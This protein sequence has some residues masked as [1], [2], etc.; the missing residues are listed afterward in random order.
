M[1]FGVSLGI[2]WW[3]ADA[4]RRR[5]LITLVVTLVV[6]GGITFFL[7]RYAQTRV[8]EHQAIS[9]AE[10]VAR[11]AT[12]AR[13]V[14]SREVAGKLTRDGFGPHNEYKNHTGFVPLPSQF[15]KLVGEAAS[16]DSEELYRYR[17]L[18]KWNLGADQGLQSEFHRWAWAQ[19]EAQDKPDPSGPI[20]WRPVWRFENENG[21][22]VLH[23]MRA[24][25]ASASNCVVCHNAL[26][27]QDEI[28]ARRAAAGLTMEKQ[29][30]LH[31]LMGAIEVT[32]PL[33]KVQSVSAEQ[34]RLVT[35][36]IFAALF[37][38]LAI[39]VWFMVRDIGR[40]R[41]LVHLSWQ[42]TH[43][44]LTG[45]SNRRGF[46]DALD[47]LLLTAKIENKQHGL[48]LLD[49]DNFKQINDKYGH[50][51]GDQMLAR[52]AEALQKHVRENDTVARL[53]GD[54]F[55][56]LLAGCGH[57]QAKTIAENLRTTVAKI[58]LRYGRTRLQ[59]T[60]SVGLVALSDKRKSIREIVRAADNA[61]YAAKHAGRN[62]VVVA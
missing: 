24:D 55:A 60:V 40:A 20:D 37:L 62:Q 7:L 43:D 45:L 51:V 52:V 30:R 8:I 17:P 19:L 50:E 1:S 54:E 53:G 48:C 35:A 28:K 25:P 13:T 12:V 36:W 49:L 14:Y 18:S 59:T 31:Q 15:L 46:E 34:T 58:K 23:Y 4:L 39:S 26:E 29:W 57:E 3:P 9:L 10:S 41:R 56:V 42:A 16:Q 2:N 47:R 33:A 61:C 38:G 44:P 21:A 27:R 11:L 5:L 6:A 22:T 32:I